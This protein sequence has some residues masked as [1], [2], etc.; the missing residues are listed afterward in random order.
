MARD[1]RWSS[2]PCLDFI[3]A[4]DIYDDDE[5]ASSGAVDFSTSGIYCIMHA[6]PRLIPWSP[7]YPFLGVIV[8]ASLLVVAYFVWRRKRV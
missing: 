7:L 4:N 1:N 3:D 6:P 2:S 5:D 8:I